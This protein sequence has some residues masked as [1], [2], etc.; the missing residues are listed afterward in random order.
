MDKRSRG[1]CF[2]LNN[3]EEADISDI[4]KIESTYLVFGKE[5]GA[6]GTPHLQGFVYFANARAGKSV[7]KAVSP[8]SHVESL[9]GT[10]KQAADYCKKEGDFVEFGVLPEQGKRDDLKAVVDDVYKGKV[11]LDQLLLNEPEMYH[12]Y[13]RTLEKADDLRRNKL[14]R[15]EMTRGLWIWGPSGVGKSHRAADY[16]SLF[17]YKSTYFHKLNDRGWWDTY[18]NEDVVIINEFRGE[19]SYSDILLLCD[20]WP[21][22]VPRRCR[23]PCSFTSKVVIITSDRPPEQIFNR[24][25]EGQFDQLYRRFDVWE[26]TSKDDPWPTFDPME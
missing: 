15:T 26:V 5:V 1:W 3:Y 8:R 7:K 19:L 20:K 4:S 23:S 22:S 25:E 12:Q 10:P 13:G 24:V 11:P 17:G 2:T 16:A 14:K 21:Y 9:K 18:D 6:S